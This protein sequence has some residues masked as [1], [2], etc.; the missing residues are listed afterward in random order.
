MDYVMMGDVWTLQAEKNLAPIVWH[1][2]RQSTI[3]SS[4]SCSKVVALM[5]T[6]YIIKGLRYK[7]HMTSV[8]INWPA[9]IFGYNMS[10][11]NVASILQLNI[12]KKNLGIFTMPY[13]K[14]QSLVYRG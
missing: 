12:Y 3:K 7:L 4:A 11:L 14:P 13:K 10:V 8:P 1:Y 2:K 6:L 9:F 5:T